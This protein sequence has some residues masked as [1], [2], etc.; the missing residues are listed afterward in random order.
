MA[1]LDLTGMRFG[2]L[3]VVAFAGVERSGRVCFRCRC[4]CGE[5]A[6]V[7]S[8]SL[9]RGATR[10]CGCL[11]VETMRRVRRNGRLAS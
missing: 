2:R 9:R 1:I 4:D 6:T 7:R 3:V 5:Q 10:S 8:N 11:R